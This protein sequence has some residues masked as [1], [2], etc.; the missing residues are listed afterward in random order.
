M[1]GCLGRE[2]AGAYFVKE[3]VKGAGLCSLEEKAKG[4]SSCCLNYTV[5]DRQY[6]IKFLLDLHS[7]RMR[8]SGYRLQQGKL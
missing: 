2:E 3:E 5:G 4:G 6:R 8:G 7:L 1:E